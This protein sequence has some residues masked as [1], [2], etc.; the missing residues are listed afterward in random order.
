MQLYTGSICLI[1]RF[2]WSD[3]FI[4]QISIYKHSNYYKYYNNPFQIWFAF[5]LFLENVEGNN[6]RECYKYKNLQFPNLKTNEKVLSKRI[7]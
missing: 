2:D 4:L 1:Q 6:F 7:W 5:F 3:Y